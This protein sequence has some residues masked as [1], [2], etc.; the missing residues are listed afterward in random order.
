MERQRYRLPRNDS[1]LNTVTCRH[2][3]ENG[4]RSPR[5][6]KVT[7]TLSTLIEAG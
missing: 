3:T 4:P 2:V 7:Q 6:P 5:L 1:Q